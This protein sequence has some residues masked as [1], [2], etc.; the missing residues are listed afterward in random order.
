MIYPMEYVSF[1]FSVFVT[2]HR[3]R[4]LNS[5]ILAYAGKEFMLFTHLLLINT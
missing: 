2:T 4:R 5:E 3:T 1:S